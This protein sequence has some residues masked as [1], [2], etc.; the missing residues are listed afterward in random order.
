MSSVRLI[1]PD[2]TQPIALRLYPHSL[3]QG[4]TY[5][6]SVWAKAA[7]P[8]T[9]D[10]PWPVLALSLREVGEKTFVLTDQWQECVLEGVMPAKG[11][12][13]PAIALTNPGTAWIDLVQLIEE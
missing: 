2:A 12:R 7:A 6:F 4:K 10:G 8:S 9:P 1:S 11:R 13:S 3:N 5:R